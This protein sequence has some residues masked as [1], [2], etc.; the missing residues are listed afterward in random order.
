MSTR[1][2]PGG[3]DGRCLRVLKGDDLTTFIVPE[4]EKI[5]EP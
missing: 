4:V 5:Q 2:T 3:E 1:K